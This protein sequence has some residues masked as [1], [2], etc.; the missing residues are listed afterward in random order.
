M[1][2]HPPISPQGYPLQYPQLREILSP[3]PISQTR[4]VKLVPIA[5]D[6]NTFTVR[7]NNTAR[8]LLFFLFE[9]VTVQTFSTFCCAVLC[10]VLQSSAIVTSFTNQV[11]DIGSHEGIPRNP[12][13]QD[14]VRLSVCE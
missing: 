14:V 5:E 6:C 9:V 1:L 4:S 11:C 8:L 7:T 12:L 13:S 10:V 2:P 3:E